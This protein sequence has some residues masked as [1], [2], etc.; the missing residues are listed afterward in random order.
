MQSCDRFQDVDWLGS[1]VIATT[2][3]GLGRSAGNKSFMSCE[4]MDFARALG[5]SPTLRLKALGSYGV[6]A[7][8]REWSPSMLC[9]PR[10]NREGNLSSDLSSGQ[11]A[12]LAQVMMSTKKCCKL[13]RLF[14]KVDKPFNSFPQFLLMRWKC[15]H[16]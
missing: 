7:A 8:E 5:S 14:I 11:G 4:L 3:L 10:R 2:K 9:N 1:C 16:Q 15:N 13:G 6:L 12:A